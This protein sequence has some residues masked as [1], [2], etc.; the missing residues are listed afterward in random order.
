MQVKKITKSTFKSFL[1]KNEGK[2]FIQAVS[3]FNGMTDG[4]EYVHSSKRVWK[5]LT[6]RVLKETDY[7]YGAERG[8]TAQQV[9]DS[10]LANE[11][12]LGYDGVWLVNGSRN[13]FAEFADN[14]FR[15]IEVYNCCGSFVVAVKA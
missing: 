11:N 10:V 8:R 13:N 3:D 5:S 6:R 7:A 1:K 9:E 2:L 15:G 12:T 14:G 4:V